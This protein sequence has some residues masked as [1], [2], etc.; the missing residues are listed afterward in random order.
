MI[1]KVE[2]NLVFGERWELYPND[3]KEVKHINSVVDR[4]QRVMVKGYGYMKL[5]LHRI[6]LAQYEEY[7]RS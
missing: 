3:Q 2:I 6:R 5:F 1:S 4:L 7:R